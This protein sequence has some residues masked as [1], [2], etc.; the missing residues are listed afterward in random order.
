MS[1]AKKEVVPVT[2]GQE[3]ASPWSVMRPLNELERAFDR[4]LDR[5]WTPSFWRSHEFPSLESFFQTP[6]IEL[7]SPRIPNM[8]VVDHESDIFVK[9]EVPGLEKK[10][11]TVTV[12][13]D[14]LTVKGHSTKEVKEEEGDYYQNEITSSSFVRSVTLPSAVDASKVVAS[15]KDG[16]L[17]IKLPKTESS[18]KRVISIQ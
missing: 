4:F 17:E 18:K 10:D 13:D 1:K 5:N 3:L 2:R 14:F 7:A 8:N 12:N 6:G 11:L 9:V 15:L 16:L